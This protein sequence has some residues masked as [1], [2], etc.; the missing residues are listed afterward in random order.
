M[1]YLKSFLVGLG[2]YIL[3]VVVWEVFLW[4]YLQIRLRHEHP[5]GEFFIVV[6]PVFMPHGKW[7]D[8]YAMLPL[9]MG[10]AFGLAA[11]A[12]GFY[13]MFRR[14]SARYSN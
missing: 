3:A 10:H 13:W 4:I 12:S 5:S 14:T 2:M 6:Q 8:F 11:F 9:M 1:R 7:N